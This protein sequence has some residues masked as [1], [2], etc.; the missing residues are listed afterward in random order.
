MQ[1]SAI[2]TRVPARLLG[3]VLA[4]AAVTAITVAPSW[5]EDPP[6]GDPGRLTWAVSPTRT[7]GDEARTS[8]AYKVEEG[9]TLRDSVRIQNFSDR[10]LPLAV[11]ASDALNSDTGGLDMLP[12]GRTPRD[13]GA[14]IALE[15]ST[16]TLEPKQTID[17]PFEMEVPADAE[18]GDHTGGIVTSFV[19]PATTSEGAKVNLDNR[20]ATRVAVRVNGPLTP[21]LAVSALTTA[22]R[23]NANPVG[24]GSMDVTYRV[25]NTGNVRLSA[26]QAV[27]VAG[28]LG[29]TKR[30]A[31]LGKMP[32]VLP[33]NS[34]TL[35]ATV[36]DVWP[37][38]R[39]ETTIRL[40]PM[41]TLAGDEF[42]GIVAT[43][44][45][46]GTW[47][48]PWF[49]LLLV[50]LVIAAAVVLQAA[51]AMARNREQARIAAAVAAA[52]TQQGSADEQ[53]AVDV[54]TRP[55]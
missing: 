20:L 21:G 55:R 27:R 52:R 38:V 53:S 2:S 39:P 32:E 17:I 22:Y 25:T 9:Q 35:K 48:V 4:A 1:M 13:V 8:F 45:S 11:F 14:W 31:T 16:I 34:V 42:S 41:P 33:G 49:L 46:A 29:L 43:Q 12:T 10:P 26:E 47:A 44:V 36:T 30:V 23:G 3:I 37:S 28:P 24:G 19:T 5:A 51:R 15:R 18:P 54:G 40:V 7:E 50:F 6:S